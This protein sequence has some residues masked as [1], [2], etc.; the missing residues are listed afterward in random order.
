[1]SLTARVM[2]P[3]ALLAGTALFLLALMLAQSLSVA[4]QAGLQQHLNVISTQLTDAAGALAVER[5][6]VS[7]LLG[8]PAH[9]AA[10]ARATA[11][12]S[13][14]RGEAT[15]DHALAAV[16]GIDTAPLL[17]VRTQ[18][19]ALRQG[20][21]QALAGAAAQAPALPVWFGAATAQIDAVVALRRAIDAQADIGS[22]IARLIAVRD[23]LA[24]MSEYAGRQRGLLNGLI[25]AGVT[26]TPEQILTNVAAEGRI[27]AAWAPIHYSLATASAPLRGK[28]DDAGRVW[29]N[30]FAPLRHQVLTAAIQHTA[31]PVPAADWFARATAGI[32][33]LLAAQRQASD[34]IAALSA[35]QAEAEKTHAAVQLGLLAAALAVVAAIGWYVLYGIARPLRRATGVIE[36]LAAGD[37]DV[38]LPPVRRR[39]EVGRLLAA[40]AHFR[41]LA[42]EG[43]AMT[44]AQAELRAQ[45]ERARTEAM[46]EVGEMVEEIG[47]R[48][49]VSVGGKADDLTRVAAQLQHGAESVAGAAR[50]TRQDAEAVQ[51]Q[52]DSA[53]A[54]AAQLAAAIGEIAEQ[55]ERA[56]AAT[57]AAVDRTAQ[58]QAV[59]TAL[60]ASVHEI[61][62][63]AALIAQVAGRT[64]LLALN[65]TI[66]AA[67]AGEAGRG[68]AVV[69]G[70]VKA[71][72]RETTN[73]TARITSRIAAI[74]TQTRAVST[75]MA[76]I[77]ESVSELNMVA[78]AVAA[79]VEQQSAATSGI[80]E[81]ARD[82]RAAANRSAG[83]MAEVADGSANSAEACGEVTSIARLVAGSVGDM[84][85]TL[86]SVLR[87][88]IADLDRRAAARIKVRL[89]GRLEFD[90]GSIK[91]TVLD[92]STGGARV[93]LAESAEYPAK[94]TSCRL[95]ADGL[96]PIRAEIVGASG[97][98]LHLHFL[99]DDTGEQARMASAVERLAVQ[100]AA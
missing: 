84:Q 58:A 12:S 13:R 71:L 72:A 9:A 44:E 82:A 77:T 6:T 56:A 59:F 98:E 49:I 42:R 91:D 81:A 62:E 86:V 39:D 10:P 92:V 50:L 95:I 4:A 51:H 78:T 94:G 87:T 41:D 7:G 63:V 68:F 37:L 18:M 14:A 2:L 48:V 1:M 11:A 55:M 80:A 70:E 25:A 15:L 64:N 31:W 76:G 90:G 93:E 85:T 34:D 30:D 43:R 40:T 97:T 83:R 3:I 38:A 17:A 75:A 89:P 45:A 52:T 28:V 88:R 8:D 5:G 53:A 24:E 27:D 26:A 79:A 67:R 35:A 57:R 74:E 36:Q 54:A 73:S 69:A 32:N 60:D 66:E 16:T 19:Q 47:A 22:Q 100:R 21:D 61:G 46:R 33:T 65:A 20:V 29:F 99:F 96:P 23:R